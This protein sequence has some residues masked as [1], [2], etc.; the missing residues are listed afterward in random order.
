[1]SLTSPDKSPLIPRVPFSPTT[2]KQ[3][4]DLEDKLAEMEDEADMVDA[5]PGKETLISIDMLAETVQ[6]YRST[7]RLH[8]R[9]IQFDS[10]A[11][12]NQQAQVVNSLGGLLK[13]LAALQIRLYDSERLKKLETALIEMLSD[14]PVEQQNTFLA[15]YKELTDV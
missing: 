15:R 4:E 5:D 2:Q 8:R 13:S 11:P 9:A 14:L 6:L 7:K 1:M 10:K 12:L 3:V